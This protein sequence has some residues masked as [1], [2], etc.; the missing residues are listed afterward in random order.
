LT[1]YDDANDADRL[2]LDP[3]MRA[4]VD[5][6]DFDRVEASANQ[7]GRFEA[8]WLLS[9][10]NVAALIELSGAWI[11]RVHEHKPPKMIV[12]DMDS[13]ES[14]SYGAS[15]TQYA[16]PARRVLVTAMH[17]SKRLDGGMDARGSP[18]D[19]IRGA[20]HNDVCE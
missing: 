12:L 9:E 5:R 16:Q 7:M 1:G 4:I 10:D 14:P 19:L 2:S 17:G 20:G 3:A 15:A 8:Q 18:S 13:S 6:K 11:P